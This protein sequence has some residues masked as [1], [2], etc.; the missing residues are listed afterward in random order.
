MM[1]IL[2]PISNEVNALFT[3]P[4]YRQIMSSRMLHV[5]VERFLFMAAMLLAG[6]LCL[7][8]A[9]PVMA[10]STSTFSNTTTGTV[11]GTNTCAAP[12]VRNFSVGSNFSIADVNIGILTTHTWRGDLQ[13]TLQS[14]SGT[15]VQL[16]NGDTQNTSGDNFNVLLDDSA[17]QLVNTDSPTGNHSTSAPPYQNTFR[18]RNLLSAFNGENSA[19]TWRLEICDL[20]PSA[21]NGSFRRADL[22]LT[23]APSNYADLSLTKVLVG[24]PPVQGGTAT[25]RLTVANEATSPSTANNVVV[26]DTFPGGFSFSSS[27]GDGSFNSTTRD[28]SVGS[29]APGET[30]SLTLVGTISSAAG[31]TI[32]NTA[33]ITASSVPDIDSTVNNGVT[34]EDDYASASFVVQSGRAPGVPPILSCPAGFSVFDWDAIPGW[35]NGSI[36]N[37]Y[38]FASFGNVRFQLTNDGAYLNNA[39]FGGQTPTVFDAFTGGLVPAEDS[40]TILSN[41]PNQAGDVEITIT[42][43][44]GFTGLQFTIF[45][46]DFA[47]NQFT[48]RVE[49]IGRNGGAT[50]LPTLTN[51][52]VNTV[53]GNVAIGDGAS[54]NNQALGNVVV[55]FTQSVDTVVIRYGNHTNAPADPGQQGI[56]VH[57]ITVCDPFTT[58]SVSKVSSIISDPVNGATNPKAIPG[59]TVEYLITVSNTGSEPADAD[60]V[61]VWDDGPA[62]AKLCLI[63]RAGGP[64][65]FADPGS[66]SNL[67]YSFASLASA[68]DDLEFSNDNG[69]S[70]AY[71]PSADAEGCD[72]AVTDFRVRPGGAFAGGG[73]FTI[74]VRYRIE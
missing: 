37:A 68:I 15:R 28:W 38:A 43:P 65:I 11:N 19:G 60:S 72:T 40:L 45:D 70:F 33:Q 64:V 2:S 58:L 27:S 56:G 14:P 10:Q 7:A 35:A 5:S 9:Q 23:S 20:F 1:S 47:A 66:N 25:W 39:T 54:A 59:A 13:F 50:V 51:G 22:Y 44:R 32:T 41:Q 49:V 74:T 69:V 52:N 67:T 48:D 63:T 73:N 55:T 46:V 30:K 18:P 24:S 42:L 53:S 61:V 4:R 17:A 8:F 57:D 71:T 31:A 36:D 26:R 29:L 3:M 34:S 21:D 6:M 12:L 62:D 16:T